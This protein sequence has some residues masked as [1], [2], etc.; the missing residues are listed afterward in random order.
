M[1]DEEIIGRL[2]SDGD[3]LLKVVQPHVSLSAHGSEWRGRCPFHQEK[4]PS[5]Y[6]SPSKG[7]Y[8]CFGCK[9]GGDV[10]TFVQAVSGLDFVESV[11]EVAGVA[12]V[13][14]EAGVGAAEPKRDLL[15]IVGRAH[16]YYMSHV[17]EPEA[18]EYL[19][20]RGLS[21]A[22]Q[23]WQLGYA[24][25]SSDSLVQLLRRDGVDLGLAE[26]AGVIAQ[27]HGR[28]YDFFRGRL[29]FPIRDHMD[30]VV[31]FAGRS[32]AGQQPKYVNSP[33]TPLYRKSEVLFGLHHA[34]AAIRRNDRIVLVEG[35]TDVI[36]CHRAGVEEA[37]AACGTAFT[38]EHVK[39]VRR[40]A[41]T[42]VDARD[43]DPAGQQ[44]MAKSLGALLEAGV[45]VL[46]AELSDGLDPDELVQ[47]R[48]P[49]ALL[50]CVDQAKP[51]LPKIIHDI[52][53][54][55]PW[56]PLGRQRAVQASVPLL[57]ALQGIARESAVQASAGPLGVD[58]RQLRRAVGQRHEPAEHTPQTHA[59]DPLMAE[60]IWCLL[61][62]YTRVEKVVR[63]NLRPEWISAD[64]AAVVKS[65][66]IGSRLGEILY[67]S[68]PWLAIEL[69]NLAADVERHGAGEVHA[70][71]YESCL[72]V[73]LAY[74]TSRI[75]AE[76]GAKKFEMQRRRI[77][78]IE[79]LE[80]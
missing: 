47:E 55:H 73:E 78:L 53:S 45:D 2:R 1:L 19:E 15:S 72:R 14:I 75:G 67:A 27:G 60:I 42:L 63:Y 40:L 70:L 74:L 30:R 37:V 65:I 33:A 57:R 71:A 34:R 68:T 5:F 12:G 36:A 64:V 66:L 13:D 11:H 32:M 50:K 38:E 48:G 76:V 59:I 10:F 28:Y 17:S 6:V 9:A 3:L 54:S 43:P 44:A 26:R 69:R 25:N 77:G 22:V 52:S 21:D 41:G 8:H 39:R 80:G 62:H 16:R 49:E 56:T 18:V 79:E 61:H 35:Y 4:T 7:F 46:Y 31:A 23:H 20:A 58:V 51:L 24:P 29:I